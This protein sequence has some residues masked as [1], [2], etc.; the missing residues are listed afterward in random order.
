[1][2]DAES[3]A[4]GIAVLLLIGEMLVGGAMYV[5]ALAV[6]APETARQLLSRIGHALRRIARFRGGDP[7]APEPEFLDETL[8][9]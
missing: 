4:T 3:H 1:V 6:L 5:A 7:P 8:A 9:P 2:I